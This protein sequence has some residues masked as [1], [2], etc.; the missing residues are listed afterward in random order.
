M[1]TSKKKKKRKGLHW[2]DVISSSECFSSLSTVSDG[3][4]LEVEKIVSMI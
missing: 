3:V 4:Y 2:G 1:Q